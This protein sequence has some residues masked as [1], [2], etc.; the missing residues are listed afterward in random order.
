MNE[1]ALAQLRC[2]KRLKFAAWPHLIEEPGALEQVAHLAREWFIRYLT[3]APAQ[4]EDGR[5]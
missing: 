5:S 3:A 1:D 2:E 4:Q